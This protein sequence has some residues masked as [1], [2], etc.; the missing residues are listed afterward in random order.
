MKIIDPLSEVTRKERRAL[1]GVSALSIAMSITHLIPTKISALGVEFPPTEQGLF[2]LAITGVVIFYLLAFIVY[3]W[4]DYINW[5]TELHMWLVHNQPP[6]PDDEHEEEYQYHSTH[7]H[8]NQLYS[9]GDIPGAERL[10][11]ELIHDRVK[12]ELESQY[13]A[14]KK[15][16]PPASRLRAAFEFVV[17]IV[18]AVVA[19]I[20]LLTTEIKASNN[21]SNTSINLKQIHEKCLT[22]SS[23]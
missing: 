14:Q 15:K 12:K 11:N 16:I 9:E 7:D 2:L 10:E 1:L 6:V 13:Q 17:P 19:I 23:S 21:S 5:K 20:I 22:K 4:T 8:L 3:A 18:I